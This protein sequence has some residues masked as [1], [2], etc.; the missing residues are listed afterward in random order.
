MW[1]NNHSTPSHFLNRTIV[2]DSKALHVYSLTRVQAV[3]IFTG[4]A[5]KDAQ[6]DRLLAAPDL[7]NQMLHNARV[8]KRA[9][10]TELIRLAGDELPQDTTHDLA[11]ARLRQVADEVDFLRCCEG[12][13]DLADLED[14]LFLEHL[15]V[16]GVV[17]EFAG[18]GGI[19]E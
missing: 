3:R 17:L 9:Q 10:V 2:K 15:W 6:T 16:R 1:P 13:D 7:G 14:E 5:T 11:R 8:C 18:G 4:A 19:R 12:A